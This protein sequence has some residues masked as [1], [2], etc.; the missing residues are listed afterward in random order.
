MSRLST[1]VDNIPLGLVNGRGLISMH[2]YAHCIMK[3]SLSI[4]ITS[5]SVLDKDKTRS[6]KN[7]GIFTCQVGQG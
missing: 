4:I 6:S 5:G 7:L 2:N 3:V 1:G